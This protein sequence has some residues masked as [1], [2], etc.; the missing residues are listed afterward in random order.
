MKFGVA[1]L[2]CVSMYILKRNDNVC[3]T[4][5][6]YDTKDLTIVSMSNF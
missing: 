4:I 3:S 5:R 2:N 1:F 6:K